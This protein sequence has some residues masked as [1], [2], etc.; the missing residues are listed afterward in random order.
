MK[1][2][3]LFPDYMSQF[4]GMGKELYDH[5]RT[6]QE[7]FEEASS[8][9]N[10]NFVKLCF[11][12]SE[13][14]LA[15]LDH[16][17]AA[18]FLVSVSTAALLNEYGIKPAQVAGLGIGEVSAACVAGGLSFPDGLYFLHK[19][20]QFYQERINEL[21]GMIMVSIA[22]TTRKVLENAIKSQEGTEPPT[23]AINMDGHKYIVAG[24][25]QA[26]N[27]LVAQFDKQTQVRTIPLEVGMHNELMKPVIHIFKPYLEKIDV[28]DTQVPLVRSIDGKKITS[29]ALL[30]ESLI[31]QLHSYIDWA[32]VLD[33]FEECT[34]ILQIGP[35]DQLATLAQQRF[36][37]KT[38]YAINKLSD[39]E[40]LLP[41][42]V[43]LQ[44]L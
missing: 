18:I 23:L 17:A 20:A 4:V 22:P 29:G 21:D 3:M 16:A 27:A 7:Y 6:I 5:S 39:I 26:V 42:G 31:E 40:P 2:G 41:A 43:Q 11:A 30:K 38:V 33:T 1:I 37:N 10:G 35:G 9:L 13:H 24:S 8:C 12:S 19:Y 14:E 15:K 25:Q 34:H 44:A 36:P 28:N 32:K